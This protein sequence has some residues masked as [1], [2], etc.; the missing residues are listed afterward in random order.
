MLQAEETADAKALRL[1]LFINRKKVQV[2]G[3]QRREKGVR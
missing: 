3:A 2:A 1:A